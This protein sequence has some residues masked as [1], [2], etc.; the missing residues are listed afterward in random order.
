MLVRL[1]LGHRAERPN[2]VEEW[3]SWAEVHGSEL[4]REAAAEFLRRQAEGVLPAT[5]REALDLSP[6]AV[7]SVAY[8][9]EGEY[10]EHRF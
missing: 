2:F 4:H 7:A 5:Y 9:H 10:A 8:S 3:L 1:L 6:E